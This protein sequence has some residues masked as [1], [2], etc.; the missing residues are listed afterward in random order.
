M[1][2]LRMTRD[3]DLPALAIGREFR[4]LRSE[5]DKLMRTPARIV[6]ERVEGTLEAEALAAGTSRDG[7]GA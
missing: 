6:A 7:V 2:V 4:Y 3:G 5:I 1:T